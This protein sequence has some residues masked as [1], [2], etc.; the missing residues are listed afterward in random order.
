[1]R[2]RGLAL[3]L[4]TMVAVAVY[5]S[6][7]SDN[8]NG[9]NFSGNVSSVQP[10]TTAARETQSRGFAF[11][12][13]DIASR[14]FAQASCAAPH[15]SGA[16][17]TL[18][19]CVTSTT[20]EVCLPVDGDCKF[21]LSAVLEGTPT[22]LKLSFIDDTNNNIAH[23]PSEA[24]S[25]VQQSLSY[26]NGD[27]VSVEDAVVNFTSGVTT[28]HVFK[29]FDGCTNAPGTPTRT[30][31]PATQTRTPTR[32]GTPATPTPTGTPPTPTPTPTRTGTPASPTPT[33]TYSAGASL[34]E[35]PSS[36]LAF[37]FSAGAAGLLLPRRRRPPGPRG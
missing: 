20:F 15:A 4:V 23:D 36:R 34:H 35:S 12:L 5:W 3:V 14:A 11:R 18:L 10:T 7:G 27:Q 24:S 32:T 8:G 21:D 26:C 9:A 19:F 2:I 33:A 30:G 37:L 17:A 22:S 29:T 25:T 1:M 16:S 13:P 31:S 28:A 6:C